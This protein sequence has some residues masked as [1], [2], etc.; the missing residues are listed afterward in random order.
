METTVE[1]TEKSQIAEVRRVVSELGKAHGFAEKDLARAEL[2]ATE[3]STNLVKYGKRGIVAVSWF[4]EGGAAGIQIVAADQGPGF[5]DFHASARD[6]HSTGGSLGIGLGAL[7]R[8][9]D[10]FDVYSVEAAGSAMLIRVS[11]GG[12]KPQPVAGSLL[13]GGRALPKPGQDVSG[14]GWAFR[15]AGRWQRVCLVDGLGHGPLAATA[16]A[17]ALAVFRA[18]GE[19]HSTSE[20]VRQAHAALKS[21]RGAVMAV[22]AIDTAAGSASFCGVGN[23]AGVIFGGSKPQHLPSI[24]GT[25][26]YSVRSFREHEMAWTPQSTLVLNS[27]GL[28]SRWNLARSPGLLARHPA[29][30]AAVLHRDFARDLDDSTVVVAKAA[31]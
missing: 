16:S 4:E 8:S 12:V 9:A 23:I 1:V 30:T 19:A 18:A 29:L 11:A 24:E 3:A 22:V 27:D 20:I 17:E 5:S 25:V 6:G 15:Q 7:M 10:M 26:G 21:T 2:V 31:A 13:V 28:S 14:D